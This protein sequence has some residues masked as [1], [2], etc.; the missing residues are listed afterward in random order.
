MNMKEIVV[1]LSVI[2]KYNQMDFEEFVKEFEE[3]SNQ[4]IPQYLIDEFHFMG[5]NNIGFIT[6]G[7]L[8]EHGLKELR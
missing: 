1:A 5:L 4:K 3:Y 6:I 7:F 2:K 8:E